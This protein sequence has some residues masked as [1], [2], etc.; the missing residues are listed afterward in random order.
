MVFEHEGKFYRNIESKVVLEEGGHS[1]RNPPVFLRSGEDSD[2]RQSAVEEIEVLLDQLFRHNNT[3]VFISK[4]LLQRLGTS[5]PSL[6]YVQAVQQAFRDG[7][8]QDMVFSGKYGDLGATVAAILLYPEART[9]QGP[10]GGLEGSL[11][12]PILKLTHMMRAMEYK[13]SEEAITVVRDLSEVMGQFPYKSPTVFNFYLADYALPSMK[14]GAEPEPE[15]EP[16][17]MEPEPEPESEPEPEPIAPEFQILTPQYFV[18]YLNSMTSLIHSGVGKNCD[19][20]GEDLGIDVRLYDGNTG[21]Q[22]CPQGKLTWS[23]GTADSDTERTLAELDVL[24]TGGRLT[25]ATKAVVRKTFEQAPEALRLEVAQQ[26]IVMSAEFNTLGRPM[27]QGQD[28]VVQPKVSV[29]SGRPYKAVVM[30]FLAGGADTFNMLVPKEC[31]LYEEYVQVR[32]DLAL[33]PGDLIDLPTEG[34]DCTKFG[35][36]GSMNF[37]K[38]LYDKRQAAFVS[39]VGNLVEPLN[40]EQFRSGQKQKCFGL[41]SHSDSQNGAQTLVCQDRGTM[42]R[43]TGGR[44]ADGLAGGSTPFATTS[45]SLSGNSVWSMGLTTEREIVDD[46]D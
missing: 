25:N 36:H 39:N 2:A 11:R 6:D 13:D 19:K 5:T 14:M 40:K 42:P 20:R 15:P 44:I 46:T 24:L 37:L 27:P 35:L 31:P 23:S 28:R 30:L 32:T 38:S 18:G 1:F 8:Y 12:E 43:G 16:E 22:M 3:P 41:F 29:P 9:A 33:A 45:F 26:A 10:N 17:P 4:R 21:R 34:Q 7:G